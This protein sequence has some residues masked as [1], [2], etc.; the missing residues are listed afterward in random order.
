MPNFTCPGCGGFLFPPNDPDA[1]EVVCGR[2]GTRRPVR[3]TQPEPPPGGA[4][5]GSLL[6][7]PTPPGDLVE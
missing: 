4:T 3:N 1:K 2:C 5:G 7:G 6:P